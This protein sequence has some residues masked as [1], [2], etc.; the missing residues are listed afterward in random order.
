MSPIT[1]LEVLGLADLEGR[2]PADLFPRAL[3]IELEIGCGR[4]DFLLACAPPNPDTNFI[5]VERNLP[6][7]RRAANKM[8]PWTHGNVRLV[9]TEIVHLLADWFPPSSLRAVHLY[10]PDPWPKKRHARRRFFTAAN[11][12]LVAR[13]LE[14]GGYFHLRTDHEGYHGEMMEIMTGLP[15][16]RE[17]ATPESLLAHR[18]AFETRFI[19]MGQPVFRRSY[20]LESSPAGA[21]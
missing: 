2:A 16:F 6:I 17:T 13:A 20:R 8:R 3:P 18:T 1:P 19:R 10:F 15:Q 7:I 21:T 4:G 14:P 11:M 5:G 9:Q 12:A